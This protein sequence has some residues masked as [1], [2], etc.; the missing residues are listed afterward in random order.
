GLDSRWRPQATALSASLAGLWARRLSSDLPSC[1]WDLAACRASRTSN[2][3]A[4]QRPPVVRS[5]SPGKDSRYCTR[6]MAAHMALGLALFMQGAVATAHTHF[7]QVIALYD[8]HPHQASAFLYGEDVGVMSRSRTSWTLWYLGYPDQAVA[9]SQAA[10]TLAQQ[11]AH[12]LSLS[13]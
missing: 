5:N 2:A 6:R 7:A 13:F 1:C 10:V 9:R 11:L 3:V 12:P 4:M 8:A